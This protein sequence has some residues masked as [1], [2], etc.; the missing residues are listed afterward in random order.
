[1]ITKIVEQ[2]K[3]GTYKNVIPFG[4]PVPSIPYVVVK[5]FAHPMGTGY[6]ITAHFNQGQQILLDDYIKG[7]VSTLLTDFQ[8]TTRNG[9]LQKLTQDIFAAIPELQD[10]NDDDSISKERVFWMPDKLN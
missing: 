8:A 1:M 5:E 10:N 2:L 4:H 9:N 7:E 6:F 3:T